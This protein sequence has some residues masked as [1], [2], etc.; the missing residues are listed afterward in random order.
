MVAGVGYGPDSPEDGGPRPQLQGVLGGSQ[1][2]PQ[3][4]KAPLPKVTLLP[5]LGKPESNDG[6][7]VGVQKPRALDSVWV[8]LKGHPAPEH[9]CRLAE[10]S[11]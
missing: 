11:V 9:P 1:N 2:C 3:Q 6:W 7:A 10:T 4:R 5:H 8:A